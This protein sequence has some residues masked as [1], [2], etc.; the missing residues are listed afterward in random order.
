VLSAL[1]D[2][3]KEPTELEDYIGDLEGDIDPEALMKWADFIVALRKA[4]K[5]ATS[6]TQ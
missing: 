5:P 2:F 4:V 3:L 1:T 6:L